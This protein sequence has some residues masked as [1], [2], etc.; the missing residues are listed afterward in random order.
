[1]TATDDPVP[2]PGPVPGGGEDECWWAW[3]GIEWAAHPDK[4]HDCPPGTACAVPTRRGTY[5]GEEDV[6][7]CL[8]T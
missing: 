6:T 7:P 4:N 1:V 8:T 3:N 2:V 5:I